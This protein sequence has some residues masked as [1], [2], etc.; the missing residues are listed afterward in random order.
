ME[1]LWPGK[2]LALIGKLRTCDASVVK[3]YVSAAERN[4]VEYFL[5]HKPWSYKHEAQ[6]SGSVVMHADPLACASCLYMGARTLH[7]VAPSG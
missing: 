6:A 5:W 2:R 7:G 1:G 4:A 3:S